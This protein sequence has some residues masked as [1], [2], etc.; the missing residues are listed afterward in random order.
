MDML[1][2]NIEKEPWFKAAC[3]K[4]VLIWLI[5]MVVCLLSS[6]NLPAQDLM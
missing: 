1:V 4:S 2:M 3:F 5:W 6:Y